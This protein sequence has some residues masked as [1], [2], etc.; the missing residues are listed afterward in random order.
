VPRRKPWKSCRWILVVA[1]AGACSGDDGGDCPSAGVTVEIGTGTT[2]F[3]PL[4]AG[5][6]LLIEAG[7]QGGHHFILHARMRGM[8]PGDPR[9]PGQ[10]G[11][12]RTL[13]TIQ[14]DGQPVHLAQSPYRIGYEATP[15]GF[16]TLPSG[17]IIQFDESRVAALDGER[18]LATVAISDADGAC[19]TD[20]VEVIGVLGPPLEPGVDAGPE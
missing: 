12:P 6:E 17:R 16:Y 8:T 1:A 4:S 19:G 10:S 2:A 5:Q 18:L 3:E 14:H 15:D 7:P 13:F 20:A 11:N 9:L